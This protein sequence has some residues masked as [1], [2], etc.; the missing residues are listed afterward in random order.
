MT[1]T[2]TTAAAGMSISRTDGGFYRLKCCDCAASFHSP[3]WEARCP[4]CE[5]AL[6]ARVGDHPA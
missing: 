3:L 4:A 2:P 6:L 5:R 1:D